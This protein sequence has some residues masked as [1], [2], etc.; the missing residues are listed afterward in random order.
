MA[1]RHFSFASDP[2]CGWPGR[3]PEPACRARGRESARPAR[4]FTLDLQC[5]CLP[6][7][8][9]RAYQARPA[10]Q[11]DSD[12][13][14]RLAWNHADKNLALRGYTSNPSACKGFKNYGSI[15]RQGPPQLASRFSRNRVPA[16]TGA[17]QV[18]TRNWRPSPNAGTRASL[19]TQWIPA[20][21]WTRARATIRGRC[22]QEEAA[23]ETENPVMR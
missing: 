18:Y 5:Q 1:L 2:D 10:I 4:L 15:D 19:D 6:G 11:W 14:V 21:S 12:N 3:S 16:F 13:P 9:G 23:L 20:R 7:Q 17:D 8:F 22:A